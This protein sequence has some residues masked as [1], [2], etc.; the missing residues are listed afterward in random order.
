MCALSKHRQED[1][2]LETHA[3]MSEITTRDKIHLG[4]LLGNIRVL[5]PVV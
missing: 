2:G 5:R 4:L 3:N 1:R